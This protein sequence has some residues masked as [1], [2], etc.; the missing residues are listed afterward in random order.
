[1]NFFF[2]LLPLTPTKFDAIGKIP[3][4]CCFGCKAIQMA[5]RESVLCSRHYHGKFNTQWNGKHFCYCTY[6]R[7]MRYHTVAPWTSPNIS[8]TTVII[9]FEK[10]ALFLFKIIMFFSR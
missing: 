8:V 1:M 10:I 6:G 9:T 4:F 5:G 3:A 7:I 2:E